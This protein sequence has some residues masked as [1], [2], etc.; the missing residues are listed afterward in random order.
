MSLR[1]SLCSVGGRRGAA[2]CRKRESSCQPKKG[3]RALV[4]SSGGPKRVSWRSGRLG[5]WL[6][7]RGARKRRVFTDLRIY[8]GSPTG[9]GAE[10]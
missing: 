7:R 10:G 2:G 6:G 8:G 9:G 3:T 1:R 4:G 5:E